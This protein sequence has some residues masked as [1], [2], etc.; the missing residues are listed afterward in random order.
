MIISLTIKAHSPRPAAHTRFARGG[1]RW[2]VGEVGPKSRPIS[3]PCESSWPKARSG[4]SGASA[5]SPTRPGCST[6]RSAMRTWPKRSQSWPCDFAKTAK[7]QRRSTLIRR[8]RQ[9]L[10]RA[11]E[12]R[13][14]MTALERKQD[15]REKILL[16]GIVVKAGLRTVDKAVLLGALLELATLDPD[17]P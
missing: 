15:A 9:K 3:R 16:G 11:H 8:L 17:S 5:R 2:R 1:R 14:A 7:G 12:S 13:D 6:S 10:S 4:R